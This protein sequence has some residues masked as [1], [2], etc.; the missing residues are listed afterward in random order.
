MW[1]KYRSLEK[2]K[3][4]KDFCKF[5]YKEPTVLSRLAPH[6]PTLVSLVG[7]RTSHLTWPFLIMLAAWLPL[8]NFTF[9]Y[10]SEINSLVQ[11]DSL[12][13]ISYLW[14]Q[15]LVLFIYLFKLIFTEYLL[16]ARHS[17]RYGG[18]RWTS[19]EKPHLSKL[20]F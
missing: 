9:S 8:L 11:N 6:G 13:S 14:E 2:F 5:T 3:C 7:P 10:L 15:L 17:S 4:H 18:Q 20:T 16:R 1:L 12:Y 19:R